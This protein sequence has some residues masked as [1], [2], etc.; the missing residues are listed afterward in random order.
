M[1]EQHF[2]IAVAELLNCAF[3]SVHGPLV[4]IRFASDGLTS[5]LPVMS[6]EALKQELRALD[7]DE[8][9]QMT[10][11]LV[12]LQEERDNA[13]RKNLLKRLIV[14]LQSLP[15]WKTWTVALGYKDS[16]RHFADRPL[17]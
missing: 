13:Y 2:V 4:E 11:F 17:G 8:Q 16:N 9:R 5:K 14:L 3:G 10:A 12:S 7:A 1:A 15:R 6:I